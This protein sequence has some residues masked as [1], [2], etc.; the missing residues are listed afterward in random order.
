MQNI[1]LRFSIIFL[2][3]YSILAQTM[4]SDKILLGF[5]ADNSNKQKDLEAKF[6]QQLNQSK[7]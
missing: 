3:S 1:F 2:L 5:S 7:Q 6:E 4:P